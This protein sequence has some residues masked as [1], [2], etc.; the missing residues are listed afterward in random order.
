MRH[1]VSEA[2]EDVRADRGGERAA[3]LLEDARAFAVEGGDPLAGV[4]RV[5]ASSLRREGRQ[6]A[7]HQRHPP[8]ARPLDRVWAPGRA[9]HQHLP[10]RVQPQRQ[11]GTAGGTLAWVLR[12]EGFQQALQH[13]GQPVA[14]LAAREQRLRGQ[15]V[16]TQLRVREPGEGVGTRE[17]LEEEEAGGPEVRAGIQGRS[18]PLLR[19]HVRRGAAPREVTRGGA[20]HRSGETEVEELRPPIAQHEDVAGLEVPVDEVPLVCVRESRRDV[21]HQVQR[22]LEA[23]PLPSQQGVQG[24]TLQVL[25]DQEGHPHRCAPVS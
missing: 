5:E 6:L 25:H 17:Q 2:G 1:R 15:E 3:M 9:G 20:G 12:Q 18:P 13:L 4:L 16:C 24:F 7:G 10:R 19:G 14:A 21:A 8:P 22:A 23:G 11:L